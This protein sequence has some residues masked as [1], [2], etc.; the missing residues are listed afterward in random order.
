MLSYE[1]CIFI[2]DRHQL[3]F[4]HILNP[5]FHTSCFGASCKVSFDKFS[6]S[7][8]PIQH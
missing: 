3:M 8:D 4:S 1:A 7:F 6:R 2:N 5:G